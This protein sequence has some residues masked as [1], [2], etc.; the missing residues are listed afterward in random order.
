MHILRILIIIM[1]YHTLQYVLH[2]HKQWR[3]S[4]VTTHLLAWLLCSHYSCKLNPQQ[5]MY[6]SVDHTQGAPRSTACLALGR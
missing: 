4:H 6:H 5:C 3:G 2:I 1:N